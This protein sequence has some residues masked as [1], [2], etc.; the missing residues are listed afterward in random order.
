MPCPK[1]AQTPAKSGSSCP[2]TTV[3]CAAI[4]AT[5][6]CAMVSLIVAITCSYSIAPPDLDQPDEMFHHR[7]D[8]ACVVVQS[9]TIL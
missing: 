3:F 9:D 5:S 1:I 7:A 2:S 8:R 6:A 4:A